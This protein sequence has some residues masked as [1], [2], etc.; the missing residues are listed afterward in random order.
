MPH[1]LASKKANFRLFFARFFLKKI[2]LKRC[3]SLRK[4]RCLTALKPHQKA[5]KKTKHSKALIAL[6]VSSLLRKDNGC[7]RGDIRF[8]VLDFRFII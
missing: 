8:I 6:T 4:F 3:L 5:E 7:I 1:F 2:H